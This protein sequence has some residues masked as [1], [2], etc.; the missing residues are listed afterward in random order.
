MTD[1]KKVLLVGE[2]W[3]ST[4][5]HIKGFDQFPT[6]TFHTG[7]DAFEASLEGS[8]FDLTVMPAHRAAADFP[9]TAEG[10]AEWDAIVFS[11]IGANTL[12][13]HPDV[14]L[15]GRPVANRLKLVRDYVMGGG[16]FMMVGGYYS[17]QGINGGARYRGTAIEEVLPVTI[18]PV[19]D[20]IE[21]PEGFSADIAAPGDPILDGLT[22]APWPLLLGINEVVAKPGARVL[23]RLPADQGG[24]PLLVAGTAGQGRTLAWTS[25]LGPHWCPKPF[26]DWEGYGRLWVQCLD[27]LAP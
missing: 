12:L 22:G 11:D 1:R 27:W 4:A 13:L 9:L 6:V 3:V 10:L 8:R 2:S 18:H 19:D 26:C 7:Q 23:A 17:F 15:H 5:T 14:W 20:R 24:H 25:D 21:I 16:G